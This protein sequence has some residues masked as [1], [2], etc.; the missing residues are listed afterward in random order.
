[1]GRK[2][3]ESVLWPRTQNFYLSFLHSFYPPAVRRVQYF[4]WFLFPLILSEKC[5]RFRMQRALASGHL[6]SI[7]FTSF[8]GY[9]GSHMLAAAISM[10]NIKKYLNIFTLFDLDFYFIPCKGEEEIVEHHS[11][12]FSA[13]AKWCHH[14]LL[15]RSN[16]E[17]RWTGSLKSGTSRVTV[18]RLLKTETNLW[19]PPT[20]PVPT[21]HSPISFALEMKTK[22]TIVSKSL[23]WKEL[24]L[25]KMTQKY[26]MI[27]WGK[28]GIKCNKC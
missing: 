22:R 11:C 14:L 28:M 4:S 17:G 25:E 6:R 26:T 9:L 16:Q 7:P 10:S 1:M 27:L 19:W 20:H 2:F 24:G 13:R 8:Q 21:D 3:S 23:I 5:E 15:P 18:D 12:S